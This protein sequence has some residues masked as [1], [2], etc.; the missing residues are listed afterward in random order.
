MVSMRV[1]CKYT[2]FCTSLSFKHVSFLT[3]ILYSLTYSPLE[4]FC[5]TIE[6]QINAIEDRAYRVPFDLA[7]GPKTKDGA[8]AVSV[9]RTSLSAT[10]SLL[11][12]KTSLLDSSSQG[13][14]N[15]VVEI[16]HPDS[17]VPTEGDPLLKSSYQNG[18]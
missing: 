4:K 1:I 11:D 18:V 6:T 3:T 17:T 2:Y 12:S 16:G 9:R 14:L 13:S 8:Y 5:A 15:R 7:T 10:T